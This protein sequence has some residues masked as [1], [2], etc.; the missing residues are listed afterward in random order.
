MCLNVFHF[1]LT[2]IVMGLCI[3]DYKYVKV[4]QEVETYKTFEV[5]NH[6]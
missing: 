6:L 3:D 5:R 2:F 1:I 4:D